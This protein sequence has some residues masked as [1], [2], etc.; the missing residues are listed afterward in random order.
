MHLTGVCVDA[1]QFSREKV[2]QLVDDYAANTQRLSK[3]RWIQIEASCG[4]VAESEH[5]PTV[6]MKVMQQQ[7]RTLYIP[8]SPVKSSDEE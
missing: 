4:I 3:R 8:S 1:G 5:K 7:R 2:G 6:N